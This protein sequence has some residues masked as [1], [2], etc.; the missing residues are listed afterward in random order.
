VNTAART[1]APFSTYLAEINRTPLLTAD[2]EKELAGRV[3]T[4]DA[5]ARDWMVR[6]NLRLVVNIARCAT[7]K[8]LPIEDLVAEGNMGLLRAVEA[9][10]PTKN[11]RF[12]T[13]A[14]YWIKQS[15]TRGLVNT[16]RTIRVPAYM[17]VLLNRRR[18]AT[19]GLSAELGRAP[20]HEEVAERMG[21]SGKKL[22][23]V[24]EAGR[25]AN[26]SGSGHG[27]GSDIAQTLPDARAKP[28]GAELGET[29]DFARVLQLLGEI[30][31][32]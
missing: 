4:G 1:P 7:G 9:F 3:L 10:D 27:D 15:I 13:Y 21:L 24:I 16:A 5:E 20:T 29:E 19:G 32:R 30:N 14:S 28:P 22:K 8:G 25:A 23:T 18:R 31:P 26:F 11:T 17:A 12:I 6:A 2:Q